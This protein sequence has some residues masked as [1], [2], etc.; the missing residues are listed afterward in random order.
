MKE[1]T[2]QTQ[3]LANNC[4]SACIA[5]VL[6]RPVEEVTAEFHSKYHAH[7]ISV[8]QY[9]WS[10]GCKVHIPRADEVRVV[11]GAVYL[12]CVP[13]LSESGAFHCVLL[14]WRDNDAPV[15]LD[16]S[17]LAR[18]HYV[19][20]GQLTDPLTEFELRSWVVDCRIDYAPALEG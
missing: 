9:L 8:E 17:R 15:L 5:M 12:L 18:R 19:Y 14:D 4:V 3:T 13:S 16:P 6:N 10:H 7:Q 11:S 2:F 1:I 20:P